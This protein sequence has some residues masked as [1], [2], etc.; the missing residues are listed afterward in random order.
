[1]LK[2]LSTVLFCGVLYIEL[3]RCELWSSNESYIMYTSVYIYVCVCVFQY[4]IRH[5]ENGNTEKGE[6]AFDENT[7]HM[8][9]R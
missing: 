9:K 3:T 7:Y 4:I 1:M 5:R 2:L 6:T 8:G